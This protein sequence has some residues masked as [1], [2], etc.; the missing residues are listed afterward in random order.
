MVETGRIHIVVLAGIQKENIMAFQGLLV[1][2]YRSSPA[3]KIRRRRFSAYILMQAM[4]K[5]SIVWSTLRT[6]GL[7]CFQNVALGNL[8]SFQLGHQVDISL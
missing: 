1:S 8:K 4:I 5:N 6:Q 3:P 7:P 2:T